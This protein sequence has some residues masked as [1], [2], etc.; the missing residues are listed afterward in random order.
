MHKKRADIEE[1]LARSLA[2]YRGEQALHYDFQFLKQN[3]YSVLEDLRLE[4]ENGDFFQIDCLLLSPSYLLIL[5]AKNMSGSILFDQ[6]T[7]HIIHNKNGLERS[8]SDPLLQVQRQRIQ[9]EKWLKQQK[10]P[11]VPVITQVV[12]SNSDTR[13]DATSNHHFVYQNVTSRLNLPN[14]T[15]EFESAHTDEVLSAKLIKQIAKSLIK[16]STPYNPDLMH[17]YELKLSD[18]ILG[19]FCPNADCP[20]VR[21]PMFKVNSGWRCPFCLAFSRDAHLTALKDYVLLVGDEISNSHFRDFARMESVFTASRLLKQLSLPSSGAK[22]NRK[23][24][25]SLP[26]S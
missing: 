16:R 23:Y 1:D 6:H 11:F 2:G 10:F 3:H 5:E 15:A 14:R 7:R 17:W 20:S 26:K 13:Y 19:V 18:L 8:Y 24:K 12:I 4:N 25:L 9:L 22:K 21:D